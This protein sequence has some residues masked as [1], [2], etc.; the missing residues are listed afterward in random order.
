VVTVN[1]APADDIVVGSISTNTEGTLLTVSITVDPLATTGQR[2]L[3][4]E[5]ADGPISIGPGIPLTIDIQ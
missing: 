4:L 3:I 1:L 5:D 2:E